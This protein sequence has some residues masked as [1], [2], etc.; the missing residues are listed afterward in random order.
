MNREQTGQCKLNEHT[1]GWELILTRVLEHPCQ[2]VWDALTRAEELAKWGPFTPSS[3]LLAV[4]SVRLLHMNN[5][6]EDRREGYVHEVVPPYLLVFQWGAD[7]L[8]WELQDISG[9]TILT[10][11]HRFTDRPMAP[12]YAAGWHLCLKGLSGTLDGIA[13][14]SMVGS[15]AVNYGY[16]EL[17]KQYEAEFDKSDKE[18]MK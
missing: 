6:Q 16:K 15:Q 14:P 11:R 8:R 13:M 10:L 2:D 17:Y 3:D 4:G 12:S 7:M 1:D 5:P 18:A 9:M